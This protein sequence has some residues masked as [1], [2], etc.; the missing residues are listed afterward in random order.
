MIDVITN[1]VPVEAA[2]SYTQPWYF[3]NVAFVPDAPA[4]AKFYQ[5]LK[6]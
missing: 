3:R 1:V 2:G 4:G 6:Q 5:L